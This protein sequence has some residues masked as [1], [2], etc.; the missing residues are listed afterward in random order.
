MVALL[1]TF[2]RNHKK[3]NTFLSPFTSLTLE[4]EWEGE[5]GTDVQKI[6]LKREIILQLSAPP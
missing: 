2:D 1:C 3:M 4:R 5:G 6:K